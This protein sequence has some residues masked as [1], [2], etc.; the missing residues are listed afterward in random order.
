MDPRVDKV[1]T[2]MNDC[3]SSQVQLND[4]ARTVNLSPWRLCHIFKDETGMSLVQYLRMLRM[5]QAKRL[6]EATFLSV[7]QV[8]IEVG[9]NDQSHFVRD[10]K[11]VYGLSPLKFR[12]S[13]LNISE[14]EE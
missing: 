13:R 4:L 8:M 9:V 6:L 11:S 5:K 12:L 7:K 3:Y 14:E 1:I 2:Y 10:F